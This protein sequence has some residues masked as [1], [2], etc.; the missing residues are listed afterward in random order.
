MEIEILK[1]ENGYAKINIKKSDPHTIFNLIRDELMQDPK[2]D[3][4]GYWRNESF[5]ES[6]IF[7]VRMKDESAD[8][9]QAIYNALERIKE[10]TSEFVDLC[11]I[12]MA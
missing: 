10:Q 3:F 5:Y 9:I 7:Q 11:K 1:N 8:P 6:I 12:K 2:V 4:S